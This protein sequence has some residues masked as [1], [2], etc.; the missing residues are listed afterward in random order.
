MYLVNVKTAFV[1]YFYLNFSM[2]VAAVYRAVS[3]I[4]VS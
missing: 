1:H 4:L 3:N 2:A